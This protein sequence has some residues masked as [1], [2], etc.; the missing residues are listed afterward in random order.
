MVGRDRDLEPC[1]PAAAGR[2]RRRRHVARRS[3]TP[4]TRPCGLRSAGAGRG[5]PAG[6]AAAPGNA[7]ARDIAALTST[8]RN[9]R[10][11][12]GRAGG[13]PVADVGAVEDAQQ[14][15]SPPAVARDDVSD[16]QPLDVVEPYPQGV[17]RESLRRLTPW[18]AAETAM[19]I[20]AVQPV[21]PARITGDQLRSRRRGRRTR[22]RRASPSA[23][24]TARPCGSSRGCSITGRPRPERAS[25]TTG[26]VGDDAAEA[27]VGGAPAV[28]RVAASGDTVAI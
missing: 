5:C 12:G 21:R 28:A 25:P 27:G 4:P 26:R 8:R 13:V 1:R 7:V 19:Q 16:G 17:H 2:R 9:D 10:R 24:P 15:S 18:R 3:S 23:S 20:P 6:A 14:R 22:D 11:L